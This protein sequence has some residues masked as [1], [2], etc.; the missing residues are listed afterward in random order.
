M[1]ITYTWEIISL[2]TA[3]VN[4]NPNTIVA[5]NWRK[6]GI[7]EDEVSGF[8]QGFITLDYSNPTEFILFESLTKET[9]LGWVTSTLTAG[10]HQEIDEQ[11]ERQIFQQQHQFVEIFDFPWSN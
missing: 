7:A 10:Q 6:T 9:V 5:V 3:T 8:V 2:Q 4:S 11:I 1:N